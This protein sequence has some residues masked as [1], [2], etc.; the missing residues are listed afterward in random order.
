MK[1]LKTPKIKSKMLIILILCLFALLFLPV[2]LD[3]IGIKKF[4]I[5]ES[6]VD[7]SIGAQRGY[8]IGAPREVQIGAPREV[9]IGDLI[10]SSIGSSMS[11]SIG[12]SMSSSMSSSIDSSI[13]SS[14]SS[15]IGSS[16]SSS[17]GSSIG[18]SMGS[19]MGSSSSSSSTPSG[20]SNNALNGTDIGSS[21]IK[22]SSS[23]KCSET[24]IKCVA[25]FGTNIGDK[26]CC[27]QTGVLQNTKYICPSV[28]PTCSNFKCGSAFG[29]CS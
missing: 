11:S 22:S 15:S 9:L 24:S 10:D 1:L 17:I 26:L 20:T 18:S 21:S 6:M 19:S 5:T 12:S 7:S 25:D 16:M 8:Q 28:K 3:I 2:F 23:D 4:S 13:G 14:M 29:I 27:G